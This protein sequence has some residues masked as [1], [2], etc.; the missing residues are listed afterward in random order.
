M[1]DGTPAVM[2]QNERRRITAQVADAK[3]VAAEIGVT[4]MP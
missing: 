2:G 1:D 3:V 4:P